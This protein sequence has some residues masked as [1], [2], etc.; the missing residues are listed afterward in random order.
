[1]MFLVYVFCYFGLFWMDSTFLD[2]IESFTKI[3]SETYIA[4]LTYMNTT[5]VEH[6]KGRLNVWDNFDKQDPL[7]KS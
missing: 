7:E 3:A 6:R 5:S 4:L 2:N 1:M